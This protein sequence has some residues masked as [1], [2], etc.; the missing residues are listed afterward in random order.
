[1]TIAVP[2]ASRLRYFGDDIVVRTENHTCTFGDTATYKGKTARPASSIV[3]LSTN[4]HCNP[5][6]KEEVNRAIHYF[7]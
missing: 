3:A 2:C 1:M 5:L 7:R 4:I 6:L